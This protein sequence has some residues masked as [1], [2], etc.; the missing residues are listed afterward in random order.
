M[1]VTKTIHPPAGA[2]PIIVILNGQG[3]NFILY[4]VAIGA[5]IIVFFAITYNRL[6]KRKYPT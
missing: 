4:P 2:N 6:L 1:I 3:I 5:L